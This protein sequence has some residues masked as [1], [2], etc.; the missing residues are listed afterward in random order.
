[1][2]KCQDECR[3]LE[4][5]ERFNLDFQETKQYPHKLTPL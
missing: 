4:D 3:I 2:P 1:M 5:F